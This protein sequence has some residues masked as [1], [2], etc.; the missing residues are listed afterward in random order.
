MK[1]VKNLV[2]VCTLA[3][4]LAAGC[5]SGGECNACSDDNECDP[6]LTCEAFQVPSG[7]I[8]TL[9]ATPSTESCVV[10]GYYFTG[11]IDSE[12]VDQEPVDMSEQTAERQAM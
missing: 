12:D 10:Q 4:T 3:A 8:H 9:C 1:R 6:G 2:M 5:E 11:D 7:A